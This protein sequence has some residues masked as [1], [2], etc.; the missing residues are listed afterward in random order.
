MPFIRSRPSL[1]RI[2]TPVAC[3]TIGAIL[4]FSPLANTLGFTTRPIS[5]F[6]ILVAMILVYLTLVEFAKSR[7]YPVHAHTRR[8]PLTHQQRHQRHV[9]RRAA[10]Y[11][12]HT[13]TR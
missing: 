1:P 11:A 9:R 8:A 13:T 3:A 7:F 12:R 4:P 6:L 2:I 10:R 5:F